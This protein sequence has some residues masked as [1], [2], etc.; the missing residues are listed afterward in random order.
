[1]FGFGDDEEEAAAPQPQLEPWKQELLKRRNVQ[2]GPQVAQANPGVVQRKLDEIPVAETYDAIKADDSKIN[3]AK[4]TADNDNFTASMFQG[5]S[6]A[7]AGPK[8]TNDSFY[9]GLRKRSDGKVDAARNDKQELIKNYLQKNE[10][11]RQ[12]VKDGQDAAMF[13]LDT[14][15]KGLDIQKGQ[16]DNAKHLPDSKVSVTY[17][18]ITAKML[19][20]PVSQLDG[21]SYEDQLKMV[22]ARTSWVNANSG[23]KSGPVTLQHINITDPVTKK[24][25]TRAWNP[26]TNELSPMKQRNPTTGEL[27]EFDHDA[28]F[29]NTIV[30]GNLVNRTE[31]TSTPVVNSDGRTLPQVIN[32][33]KGKDAA[34]VANANA[35]AKLDV[36]VA[37]AD[38]A[39]AKWNEAKA[40]I[41][42]LRKQAIKE[43]VTG[44]IRGRAEGFLVDNN[45]PFASKAG[46]DL[47]NT[48]ELQG[49]AYAL[50]M[51]G[52]SATD[53]QMIRFMKVQPKPLLPSGE[54]DPLYQGKMASW[55]NSIKQFADTKRKQRDLVKGQPQAAPQAGVTPN[56]P[57]ADPNTKEINGD[58]WKKNPATGKW[59]KQPKQP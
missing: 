15:K 58:I 10:L 44:P 20:I 54:H 35:G 25:K 22:A 6:T 21:V 11:Q 3:E 9:D 5:L 56:T 31:G 46:A 12:G 13:G 38:A 30:N 39:Q 23:G 50:K 1:M 24:T 19:G 34:T 27:E 42:D 55:E 45:L 36:E 41:E 32:E 47:N 59:A 53:A 14:Q 51:T 2:V 8:Y 26:Q 4:E 18:P 33:Q 52:L 49:Q 16:G 43:G 17:K 29:A 37:D 28:G 7:F 57:P 48:M 40:R